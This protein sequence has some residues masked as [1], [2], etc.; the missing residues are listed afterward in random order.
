[1]RKTIRISTL[2]DKI[3]QI[4]T[5]TT[6]KQSQKATICAVLESVLHDTGNY[7]GFSYNF[8]YNSLS[9]EDAQAIQYNRH[10]YKPVESV[11]T[12]IQ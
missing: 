5:S 2:V 9:R 7:N 3:N 6:L 12:R 4:L 8:D 1:M 10:Y 11:L